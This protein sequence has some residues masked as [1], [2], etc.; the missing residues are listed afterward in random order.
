[1]VDDTINKLNQFVLKSSGSGLDQ[2][3]TNKEDLNSVERSTRRAV[4][5]NGSASPSLCRSTDHDLRRQKK[6]HAF[7]VLAISKAL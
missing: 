5:S 6:A 4:L 2:H 1:M 3:A 7:H